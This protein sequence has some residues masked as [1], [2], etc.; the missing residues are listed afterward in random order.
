MISMRKIGGSVVAIVLGAGLVFSGGNVSA[1]EKSYEFISGNGTLKTDSVS[2]THNM[3]AEKLEK[4]TNG[5]IKSKVYDNG[6]LCNET[7]C[8]EQLNQGAIQVASLSSGN[9]GNF[10]NTFY[11]LDMPYLFNNVEDAR[12]IALGPIGDALKKKSEER[13][14]KK[15]IWIT[16][17]KGFRSLYNSER[18]MRVPADMKNIKIRTVLSPIEQ[19]LIKG[20]GGTPVMVP[21]G[22]TYQA[23][24]TKVAN[25]I[26]ML[27]QL[28]IDMK[29]NEIVK[30]GT[31]TGG[32]FNFRLGFMDLKLYNSLPQDI[33]ASI[34]KAA[35][36]AEKATWDIE[37]EE[38]KSARSN[39][40]KAGIK[41]YTPTPDELKLWQNSAYGIWDMFKDKVDQDVLK[42]I[43]AIQK[44]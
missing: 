2:K 10:T 30:Y 6:I 1:A 17:L 44:K 7:T 26:Y 25:G 41:L 37:I 43:I 18:E 15:C 5:K 42:Q 8:I 16:S 36:E 19:S 22:E 35:K 21:W 28:I 33:K 3:F 39:L 4:Y 20:W 14:K 31:F 34:D 11:V 9:Y 23:L 32:L 29:F 40:V 38:L 24:Q 12:K 27:D 13:D